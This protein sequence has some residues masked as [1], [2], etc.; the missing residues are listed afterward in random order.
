MSQF[1]YHLDTLFFWA[2]HFLPQAPLQYRMACIKFLSDSHWYRLYLGP[3][4]LPQDTQASDVG[5]ELIASHDSS[6]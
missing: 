5:C 3:I 2:T 6:R 4:P 1:G